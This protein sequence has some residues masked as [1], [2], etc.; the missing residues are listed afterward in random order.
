MITLN[1]AGDRVQGGGDDGDGS[2]HQ[3]AQDGGAW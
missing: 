2:V 3:G 1:A